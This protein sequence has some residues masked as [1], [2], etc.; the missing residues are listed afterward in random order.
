MRK[1]LFCL[2]AALTL[3]TSSCDGLKKPETKDQPQEATR[4]TAVVYRNGQTAVG[5][6]ADAGNAVGNAADNTFDLTKAELKDVKFDEVNLADVRVRGNDDYSV[7]GLEEKV[8]FDTG[9]SD[10][11]PS[12]ANA[13][14]QVVASI[15]QRYGKSQMQIMGFADSRG[16]KDFNK[17]LSEKRAE[18]VRNWLTT[19]GKLDGG[20]L[21]VEPMGEAMPTAS[22]ATAAGRKEN[23][24]VEIVVRTKG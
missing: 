3:L 16:D 4:D 13:L 17:E 24:R 8:L 18:A 15:G 5:V 9:K 19:N 20:R 14:N 23:R 22:N 21:S 2:F 1:T 7:Y 6:V 12:A 10:I 11:K